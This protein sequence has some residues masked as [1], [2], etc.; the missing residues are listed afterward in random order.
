MI[1]PSGSDAQSIRPTTPRNPTRPGSPGQSLFLDADRNDQRRA[2]VLVEPADAFLNQ[3]E[4]QPGGAGLG[5]G[6]DNE[7]VA[8]RFAGGEVA[9]QGGALTV[10]F[11][12]AAVRSLPVVAEMDRALA[13]AAPGLATDVGD[14][15][16]DADD[17]V[18]REAL[19]RFGE[20][21]AGV[22]FGEWGGVDG[23]V[24][25]ARPVVG[26][27]RGLD[28]GGIAFQDATAQL[29]VEFG[30][31]FEVVAD[32]ADDFEAGD[33]I[34]PVETAAQMAAA[35]VQGG[36]NGVF[37]H[38][39]VVAEAVVDEVDAAGADVQGMAQ[40]FAVDAIGQSAKAVVD[41][42]ADGEIVNIDTSAEEDPEMDGFTAEQGS[43]ERN[44]AVDFDSENFQL[45]VAE[46]SRGW[47]AG[48]FLGVWE[49]DWGLKTPLTLRERG[50]G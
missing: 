22:E 30:D 8:D 3:G 16:F 43:A 12:P 19:R 27:G 21:Q 10:E 32:V 49:R 29:W 48:T 4:V 6:F 18:E 23:D 11:E 7:K 40:A 14:F 33:F 20:A 45:T 2:A 31:A 34:A 38:A 1:I 28:A 44:V 5:R 25:Q 41:V 9:R 15:G 47:R 24:L 39:E 17:L 37:A 42:N 26:G 46:I 35:K 36:A 13:G 50:W